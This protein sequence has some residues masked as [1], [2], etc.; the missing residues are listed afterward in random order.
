[1]NR[2]LLPLVACG[3]GL[4]LAGCDPVVTSAATESQP[5]ANFAVGTA[6]RSW[7]MDFESGLPRALRVESA[8][9]TREAN[10][11]LNEVRPL[12]GKRD[13]AFG[14][15][16]RSG[17]P[18][19]SWAAAWIPLWDSQ[20]LDASRAI[21]FRFK[22]RSSA[23][24]TL[25]LFFDS[26]AYPSSAARHSLVVNLSTTA[27]EHSV[28]FSQFA[29]TSRLWQSGGPCEEFLG[30]PSLCRTTLSQAVSHL[31]ALQAFITPRAASATG[32]TADTALVQLD[33]LQLLFEEDILLRRA[34]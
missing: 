31:R 20:V 19:A 26:D 16:L 27:T 21:G 3:L 22:A 12:S 5:S 17:D 25:T 15:I 23:A 10:A 28:Y 24:R 34:P 9:S 7:K 32:S 1:M 33:D 14:A 13:L 18:S 11:K 6:P 30:D 2:S 8:A 4:A 29:Y